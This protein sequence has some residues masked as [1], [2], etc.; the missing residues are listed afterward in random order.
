MGET[1]NLYKT[2]IHGIQRAQE[3][4]TKQTMPLTNGKRTKAWNLQ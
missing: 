3:A 4:T 2:N 1:L